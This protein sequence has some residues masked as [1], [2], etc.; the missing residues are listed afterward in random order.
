MMEDKAEAAGRRRLGVILVEPLA[1]VRAGLQ[2]LINRE[3]DL[4]VLAATADAADAMRAL[5]RSRRS[6]VVVLVALGLEGDRDAAWL[7]REVRDRY[8][9]HAI[10]AVGSESDPAGISRAL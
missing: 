9:T 7:I 2:L 4:E 3:A 5:S 1:V 10:L 8:P 6:R